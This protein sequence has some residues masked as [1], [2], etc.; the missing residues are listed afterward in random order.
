M[1]NDIY[2]NYFNLL[3]NYFIPQQKC[4]KVERVGSKYRRFFD[5]P[6]TPYQRLIESDELSIY[7]KER[8]REKFKSL[9]PIELRGELNEQMSRFKRI[10]ENISDYKYKFAS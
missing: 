4:I 6:K 1:M 2:K 5:V 3:W 7:Q 10:L 9:N 8:L